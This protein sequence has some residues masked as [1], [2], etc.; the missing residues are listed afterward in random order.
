MGRRLIA[1]VL[2]LSVGALEAQG[3]R[4][5]SRRPLELP[6]ILTLLRGAPVQWSASARFP[7]VPPAMPLFTETSNTPPL[8]LMARLLSGQ[9]LQ[10]FPSTSFARELGIKGPESLLAVTE[11]AHQRAWAD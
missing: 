1:I 6:P 2:F 10:P 5:S 4:A 3:R 11:E 8:E 9:N 7:A